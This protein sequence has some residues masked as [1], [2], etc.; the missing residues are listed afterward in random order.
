MASAAVMAPPTARR[1]KTVLMRANCLMLSTCSR[2]L[3]SSA[4]AGCAALR[5][6]LHEGCRLTANLPGGGCR[7]S[8]RLERGRDLR[9]TC[10]VLLS[11]WMRRRDMDAASSSISGLMSV[12]EAA[13]SSVYATA[14]SSKGKTGPLGRS[15][16]QEAASLLPSMSTPIRLQASA[17]SFAV[18]LSLS[19]PFT[20]SKA[21]FSLATSR[22]RLTSRVE[23]KLSISSL[24][25]RRSAMSSRSFSTAWRILR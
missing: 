15:A 4:T 16:S 8:W 1:S 6:P 25:T 24:S 3:P 5:S 12:S 20:A 18:I 13:N 11:Y 22:N 7:C 14:K 21:T 2:A 9:D 17:A 19:E 23:R 10:P